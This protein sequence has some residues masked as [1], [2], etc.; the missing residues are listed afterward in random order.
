MALTIIVLLV[1]IIS[2]LIG[3]KKGLF[4]AVIGTLA[5]VIAL[6]LCYLLTPYTSQ[7][8]IQNTKIDDSIEEKVHKKFEVN[9]EKRI[10][11][12]YRKTLERDIDDETLDSYK[13]EYMNQGTERSEKINII[14]QINIPSFM[15][16]ALIANDNKDTYEKMGVDNIYRY[17]SKSVSYMA[18]NV[19]ACIITFVVIRILLIILTAVLNSIFGSIKLLAFVDKLGGL[20]AG[21]ILGVL[22][23]WLVMAGASVIMGNDFDTAV[24]GSKVLTFINNKNVLLHVFTNVTDVIFK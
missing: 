8:L 5:T 13:N 1:I 11:E 2:A 3:L 12:E 20:A 17:I 21:V 4:R 24:E 22:I 7:F 23:A 18:T 10:R 14:K 16:N 15:S 19:L 9:I 6:V